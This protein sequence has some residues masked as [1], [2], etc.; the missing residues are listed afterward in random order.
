MASFASPFRRRGRGAPPAVAPAKNRDVRLLHGHEA[1]LFVEAV[2]MLLAIDQ[3]VQALT[4]LRD[5]PRSPRSRPAGPEVVADVALLRYGIV[6]FVDC[7]E[8]GRRPGLPG[9]EEIF[10]AAD[11]WPTFYRHLCAFR[12]QLAGPQARLVGVTEAVAFLR[13]VN[14]QPV[15]AGVASRTLRPGRLT[16]PELSQMIDFMDHVR[17]AWSTRVDDLRGALVDQLRGL[18]PD[19]LDALPRADA[20]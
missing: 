7:F 1:A 5:R 8:A 17:A 10:A 12:Y 16:K 9:P 14:D 4:A 20:S 18:S 15:L 3:A 11:A 19:Q 2:S 6:Q 13:R